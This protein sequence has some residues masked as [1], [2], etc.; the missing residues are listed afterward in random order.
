MYIPMFG[1]AFE[2]TTKSHVECKW[3]GNSQMFLFSY[4]VYSLL[5]ICQCILNACSL[6][7]EVCVK[8][9][10]SHLAYSR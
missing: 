6:S 3:V 4:L 8:Y 2:I 9:W 10:A 1:Q 5:V 7:F